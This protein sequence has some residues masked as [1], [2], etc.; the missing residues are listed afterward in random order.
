M[1]QGFYRTTRTQ[2]GEVTSKKLKKFDS[3]NKKLAR[4]RSRLVYLLRNRTNGMC[5]PYIRHKTKVFD[6]L[7]KQKSNRAGQTNKMKERFICD[8]INME[9]NVVNDKIKS[10]RAE[11]R[12]L[13]GDIRDDMET[14]LADDFFES[15]K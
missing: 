5:P 10:K 9:I 14:R 15:Q 7:S 6:S 1:N 4:D 8:F 13:E 11:I 3:H 2:Y 12:R